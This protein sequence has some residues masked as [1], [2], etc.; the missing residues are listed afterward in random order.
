[1]ETEADIQPNAGLYFKGHCKLKGE[2]LQ[3]LSG[4][5]VLPE[6]VNHIIFLVLKRYLILCI[7][8]SMSQ[9]ASLRLQN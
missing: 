7:S 2:L 4:I 6:K 3:E 5:P 8:L 9:E 1:M